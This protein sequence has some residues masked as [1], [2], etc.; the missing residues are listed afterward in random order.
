MFKDL[1]SLARRA[2]QLVVFTAIVFSLFALSAVP[3]E[4]LYAHARTQI[5]AAISIEW[6][7]YESW[8]EEQLGPAKEKRDREL[9]KREPYQVFSTESSDLAIKDA[10]NLIN[11]NDPYRLQPIVNREDLV[12]LVVVLD[13]GNMTRI[14]WNNTPTEFKNISTTTP[15][16]ILRFVK[17]KE[18]NQDVLLISASV[19]EA[20][21]VLWQT[22]AETILFRARGSARVVLASK[23]QYEASLSLAE[24]TDFRTG[25]MYINIEGDWLTKFNSY[26]GR[27]GR[28]ER[29]EHKFLLEQREVPDT[30]IVYWLSKQYP[31]LS[32]NYTTDEFDPF[33][34]LEHVWREIAD[35]PLTDTDLYLSALAAEERRLSDSVSIFGLT[36]PA[37]LVPIAGPLVIIV[38]LLH[39]SR[40]VAHILERVNGNGEDLREFAWMVLHSKHVWWAEPLFSFMLLP[41]IMQSFITFNLR[42]AEPQWVNVGWFMTCLTMFIAVR[43]WRQL[44][45]LR[46]KVSPD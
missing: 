22:I 14:K 1:L 7:E 18:A 21:R 40:L 2:H 5:E 30:S 19:E 41:L 25:L 3:V 10:W 39:L 26:R 23:V 17:S 9:Q 45:E 28:E 8:V 27:R 35:R 33:S 36:I 37:P 43:V 42:D 34:G 29:L 44:G 32:Q 24:D 13:V 20:E 38:L 11:F 4:N 12:E 6:S 31:S 16:D 46:S 15:L